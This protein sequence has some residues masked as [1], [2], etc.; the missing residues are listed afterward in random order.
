M[1]HLGGP[2]LGVLALDSEFCVGHSE[3]SHTMS[4]SLEVSLFIPTPTGG[5]ICV[6]GTSGTALKCVE[7]TSA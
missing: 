5:Q 4:L 1:P 2:I 6:P 3:H 7:L